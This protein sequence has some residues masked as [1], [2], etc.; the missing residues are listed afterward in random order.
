MYILVL[1]PHRVSFL[2]FLRGYKDTQCFQ[3]CQVSVGSSSSPTAVHTQDTTTYNMFI[4]LI[5]A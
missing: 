4:I 1:F 5:D 2:L 3:W